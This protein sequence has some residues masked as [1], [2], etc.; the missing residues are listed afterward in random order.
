MPVEI[1]SP[2]EITTQDV[3]NKFSISR[4]TAQRWL[5]LFIEKRRIERNGINK[6]LLIGPTMSDNRPNL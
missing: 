6:E 2:Y 4:A 3:V 1:Y 5:N